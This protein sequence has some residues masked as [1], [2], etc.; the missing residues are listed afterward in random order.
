MKCEAI[1]EIEYKYDLEVDALFINVKND[2]EYDTSIE[3]NNE[4]ILDFDKNGNP[5]ALE[6]LSASNILKTPKYSL[7]RI[8]N[9]KM[10]VDINEK[11]IG[12]KLFLGVIIHNKEQIHSVNTFTSNDTGIPNIETEMATV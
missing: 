7:K 4:V 12:L 2:Y 9:I 10:N 5:V 1:F 11:S 3:L 6:I 8:N